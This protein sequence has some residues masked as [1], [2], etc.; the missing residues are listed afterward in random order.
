MSGTSPTATVPTRQAAIRSN[1]SQPCGRQTSNH[2]PS[3]VPIG[4]EG[5]FLLD[6]LVRHER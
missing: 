4:R 2:I 6:C 5:E 3:V 1:G